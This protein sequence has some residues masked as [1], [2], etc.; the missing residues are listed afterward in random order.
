[1]NS[2]QNKNIKQ[3]EVI[4]LPELEIH[5]VWEKTINWISHIRLLYWFVCT[6]VL[7]VIFVALIPH[8]MW[9][10]LWSILKVQGPLVSMLLIFSLVAI[11]LVW[12]SFQRLDVWVL[13]YFN[14]HGRRAPWLDWVMLGFTQIGNGVF[15]VVIAFVLFLRVNHILAY[16]LILGTL[17]LWLVVALMKVIIHRT[18]PYIKMNT[19]RIVGSRASG[20][21]FPSGH[22]SQAFFMV[23]LLLHYYQVGVFVSL[24]LYAIALLVGITRIYVGMHYPRDVLGGAILGTSWGLFGVIINNY[25]WLIV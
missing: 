14:M 19:I 25:I 22:T 18:R 15:A 11:S 2:L 3:P 12:S 23:T 10:V 21:S 13:M 7:L 5:G 6:T 4:R 9:M 20:H 16:E 8:Y 17:T 24:S 1:V